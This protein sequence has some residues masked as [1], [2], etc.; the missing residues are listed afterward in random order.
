M[1][2]IIL[3]NMGVAQSSGGAIIDC[4]KGP[5]KSHGQETLNMQ[6]PCRAS[7]I[8]T[9]AVGH[10]SPLPLPCPRDGS[11][12]QRSTTS[13][14][15]SDAETWSEMIASLPFKS[16]RLSK[17]HFASDPVSC[18]ANVSASALDKAVHQYL[19][20]APSDRTVFEGKLSA[21]QRR[22]F[23]RAI[24]EARLQTVRRGGGEV[25]MHIF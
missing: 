23:F 7:S 25:S 20:A 3:G 19:R 6:R 16:P 9:P 13:S 15:G 8:F 24:A 5:Q 22:V 14:V 4:C 21:Q 12:T 17:Y 11:M 2:I 10:N 18:N 1:M